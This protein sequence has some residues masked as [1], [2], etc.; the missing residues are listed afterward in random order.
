MVASEDAKIDLDLFSD[1]VPAHRG[2]RIHGFY[3]VNKKS[4]VFYAAVTYFLT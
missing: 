4:C 3:F 1:H 2:V